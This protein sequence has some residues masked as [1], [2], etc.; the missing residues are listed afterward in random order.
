LPGSDQALKNQLTLPGKAW[1]NRKQFFA[2]A[3][4]WNRKQFF[5]NA[6]AAL[7]STICALNVMP[8]DLK[9]KPTANPG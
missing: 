6:G 7:M 2:N 3:G 5:A 1:W 9:K 4:W 8:L